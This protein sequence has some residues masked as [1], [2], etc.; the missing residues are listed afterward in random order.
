ML[1]NTCNVLNKIF[2]SSIV[3]LVL[4]GCAA[5]PIIEKMEISTG[6]NLQNIDMVYGPPFRVS[7]DKKTNVAEY[8]FGKA[9]LNA[10]GY[11]PLFNLVASTS[12]QEIYRYSVTYSDQV[13]EKV[14]INLMK[15]RAFKISEAWSIISDEYLPEMRSTGNFYTKNGLFF[16]KDAWQMQKFKFRIYRQIEK[17]R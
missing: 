5:T 11:I 17:S 10:S 15:D 3:I 8:Y 4:S 1:K 9:E 14:D 13:V 12:N 6:D 7:N 16:D 2:L